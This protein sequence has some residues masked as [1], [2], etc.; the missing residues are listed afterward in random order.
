MDHRLITKCLLAIAVCSLFAPAA[1][2][3]NDA[4]VY[5]AF[6]FR[7]SITLPAIVADE[8]AVT[9]ELV[10]NLQSEFPYWSFRPGSALD[11]PRLEVWLNRRAGWDIAMN[12]LPSAG[13]ATKPADGYWHSVLFEAGE[14]DRLWTGLPPRAE[15]RTAISKVFSE[16]LL[17]Q[18]HQ[19]ILENLKSFAPLGKGPASAAVLQPPEGVLKLDWNTYRN[20]ARSTFVIYYKKDS[21]NKMIAV[22][23]EG[24]GRPHTFPGVSPTLQG[25][26]VRHVKWEQDDISRHLTEIKNVKAQS[27]YLNKFVEVRFIGDYDVE[28]VCVGQNCP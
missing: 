12:L 28:P 3:Q 19:P 22:Q 21:S 20:L 5:V 26:A 17:K 23:S 8:P 18:Q 24:T 15:L 10:K 9:L 1:Y 14:P 25:I 13:Q 11:Y 6:K 4:S 27:F 7:D 16:T 2:A